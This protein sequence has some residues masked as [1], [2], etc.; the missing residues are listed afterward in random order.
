MVGSWPSMEDIN[1]RT[2]KWCRANPNLVYTGISER[3]LEIIS[4]RLKEIRAKGYTAYIARWA[5]TQC[6]GTGYSIF[7]EKKWLLDREIARL[8]KELNEMPARQR[9]ALQSY[10][11]TLA[12]LARQEDNLRMSLA[13]Y[14]SRLDQL[15]D[16][17]HTENGA[18]LSIAFAIQ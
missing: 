3:H 7:A 18:W 12:E 8:T 6:G 14:K 10:Q 4:P 17:V 16:I 11:A 1:M 5:P 9:D 2:E 13:D 15:N